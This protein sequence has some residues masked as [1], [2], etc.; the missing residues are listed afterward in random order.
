VTVKIE[1]VQPI[2]AMATRRLAT[3]IRKARLNVVFGVIALGK[4]LV[5]RLLLSA[6]A[7]LK[8]GL[9][10]R[11]A[12]NRA[13]KGEDLSSQGSLEHIVKAELVKL[14]ASSALPQELQND[15]FRAWLL[16]E[17]CLER[18]V[19]VLIAQA[20]GD[21]ALAQRARDD[22]A[23]RYEQ[24][25]GET[26]KLAIGP[27]N[28]VVSHVY[29]QLK[30]TEPARQVLNSALALRSAAQLHGLRHPELRPF[31]S[32]ADLDRLRTVSARLLE[33][34]RATWK[35]P[36]F[37][38]SLTLEAN[39]DN[40]DKEV[41]PVTTGQLV[42]AI[43]DGDNL[44]LFGDGGIGKTTFLLELASVCALK[45]GRRTPL[46]VDAAIWA[47]AGVNV[48]DYLASTPPAQALGVTSGDLAKFAESGSLALLVNGWNE[49][50]AERKSFCRET[51][52]ILTTTAPALAVAVASR[53]SHDTASL[54]SP[55]RIIVR[56]LT[57]PG[58]SAVIR[59]ELNEGSADELLEVL[60]KD[61]RLRHAA[62][63]PLILRGLIAQAQAGAK[64][65]SNV[66]DILGAVVATL[67]GN[68]QRQ[69]TLVDA[70]VFGMQTR[71][72][73]E[74]AFSLNAR[75]NTNLSRE[76]ALS[77]IGA[78]AAHLVEERLLGTVPHPP[79]VLDIL[80]SHHV[81]HVQD[82]L[83]RF[84]HQR[85][86]EYFGASRLLRAGGPTDE[87]TRRLGDAVNE[88]A[89]AD[90]LEL[91][92]ARLK[93]PSGSGAA[94]ARLVQAAEAVD[95]A[96]ACELAGLC[97]FSESDDT[98]LHARLVSRVNELSASPLRQVKDLAVACQIASRL[99][100]FSEN[101][102][103]LFES[104]EQQTR[105][106]SHR[107]NGSRVSL[108]QLGPQAEARINAW[109]S[110][111][112]S[113]FLHEVASN[114]E[115]YD[116]IVRAAVADSDP[117][118]RA[119]AISA[120]FWSYPASTAA[121]NAWLNAPLEV[122]T[123]HDLVGYIAYGL[124]QGSV[125]GDQ[126]REHLRVIGASE[127]SDVACVQLALAFPAEVGSTAMDV[128]L[129]RLRNEEQQGSPEQ[130]IS[131]AEAHAPDRLRALALDL[132]AGQRGM[133]QWAGEL[134]LGETPEM[135][136]LAFETAWKA[137][138]AG[139]VR[140]LSPELVGP[141]SSM[142]QTRRSVAAWLR[143]CV[144]RRSKLSDSEQE[145][146]REV[147]YLLAHAPGDDLLGV[148]M[149]L[150]A[151]ASYE[152]SVELTE[153]LLTRVSRGDGSVSGAN[154]WLP[155]S[156]QFTRL[157][158]LFGGKR[159]EARN[160]QDRLFTLLACI[161][162]HVS[163]AEFGPLLL[164]ALRRHLDA[165]TAYRALLDEWLNRPSSPRPNNPSLGNYIISAL[166]RWGMDALPG[167]LQLLSHPNAS[168]LVP[169]AIGCIASL[170]WTSTKKQ[171]FSSVNTDIQ[172]GRQRRDAGRVLQQP[173][174]AYQ[175]VTDDAA[176]ALA[177][178]LNVEVDR[179]LAER[180]ENPKW[181][182]KQGEYQVGNLVGILANLPSLEIVAPVT[183]ALGSGLL[184]LYGFVGA[185]R[186]LTR[187]GWVFSDAGVV[188]GF[189]A[190]Y[191]RETSP[192]WVHESTRYALA[193]F[194]QL[195][196][197]VEPPTHL[198]LPLGHY[199]G[200]WQRF[201]HPS[202]IMRVLGD[203]RTERA[204]PL[205][206]ALG[207]ELSTKGKVPE[208]LPYALASALSSSHFAAFA[209]LVADG[210]LLSWCR[211]AW[212][213]ERIAPAVAEVVKS[214]PEYLDLLI[215]SWR[216]SASPLGDA[217]LA[218]VLIRVG[219]GDEKRWELGLEALDAGRASDPNMPAHRMLK[220]MFKLQVPLGE[221]Q[222]EVYPKACKPLRLE[223]YRRAKVGGDV[224]LA[225][226]RILASLECDRREGE[227]PSDEPRHPDPDDGLPWTSVLSLPGNDQANTKA[228]TT[229]K[230][231]A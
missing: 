83:V 97:A 75:G 131:I 159:E 222:F 48:L 210:T 79:S 32:D 54:R 78:A 173:S 129:A 148:V 145:R 58:Q 225:A 230:L 9:A 133:P 227:R 81:L 92:A 85:F 134:L 116:F 182:A 171:A 76:E 73:E 106:H 110:E 5:G 28:L 35:M 184:G 91:V 20:G 64:T 88:P 82:G 150:G 19:E 66:Y 203:M 160:P 52:K 202:E 1:M 207:T 49:I 143:H 31:P 89:W 10:K 204:W 163:P 29:G 65:S 94:R 142:P 197:L 199:V 189:E 51:F 7:L 4:A 187:Q 109:P 177:G 21:P 122:Q 151:E 53:T 80:A 90:S 33:A 101:L 18:F 40:D 138:M 164:E 120:L 13:M 190:L 219:V 170:P 113:E 25:T 149:E 16:T 103:A 181:N 50:P 44:V 84:A 194:S 23:R 100:A 99:P 126:I 175:P 161:A 6:G 2:I 141:L 63:S 168:D 156:E 216:K 56:G 61:T 218:E 69:L 152:E 36:K 195:M 95:L 118:V 155:E 212:T 74:L 70:P 107:L 117:D 188:G 205:L 98:A 24:T 38:A 104:D 146:G 217:L 60:A 11:S 214:N 153:L 27:L 201:A 87:L 108:T 128:V 224:G 124:E 43:E 72:L 30:A 47:R 166:T 102:W 176:R 34:G 57:W 22:L 96:Y 162:S 77:A 55:R 172:D 220:S 223:L 215:D 167:V 115:N 206:L 169:Q 186:A 45:A 41:R 67:E 183:R 136:E 14:A 137:L 231:A 93:A 26:R 158:D 198:K 39:E 180:K 15:F 132:V 111:R 46:Y 62:R 3:P 191:E 59:S 127:I 42:Q 211:D 209:R 226:R 17:E 221:N 119:A 228:S 86:Q 125:A 154:P 121:V 185:V 229:A 213:V 157:F 147:G 165:W 200:Q 139:E 208:E 68:D 130:L 123:K 37:V 140:R 192:V 196:F 135:R 8:D 178:L 12:R 174:P 112:R 105:L 114:S 179:Q 144:E 71:Y 193:E